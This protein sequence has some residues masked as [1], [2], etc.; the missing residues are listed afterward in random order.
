MI[1]PLHC[2]IAIPTIVLLIV[3][4]ACTLFGEAEKPVEGRSFGCMPR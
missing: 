2:R 3:P 4:S 1:M